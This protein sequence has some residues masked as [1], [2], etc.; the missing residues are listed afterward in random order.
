MDRAIAEHFG[1]DSFVTA[2]LAR[3]DVRRRTLSILSAGHPPPLL[4]RDGKVIGSVE[5]EPGTP[6]GIGL[7]GDAVADL[8]LQPHDKL[9]LYTDGVVEGRTRTG[10]SSACSAWPT[11]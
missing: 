7:R 10:S 6:P 4:L 8:S 2:L 9:L 5:T 1:A 11:S 3:L